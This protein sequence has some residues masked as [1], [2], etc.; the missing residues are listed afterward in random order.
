MDA[1]SGLTSK[2]AISRR[3]SAFSQEAYA[4]MLMA[5]SLTADGLFA[6]TPNMENLCLNWLSKTL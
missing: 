1:D 2:E 3:L 4:F 5:I 6:N